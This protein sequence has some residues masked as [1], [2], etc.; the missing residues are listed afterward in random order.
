M[1]V[2]NF[3]RKLQSVPQNGCASLLSHTADRSLLLHICCVTFRGRNKRNRNSPPNGDRMGRLETK[4]INSTLINEFIG[5]TDRS[6]CSIRPKTPPLAWGREEGWNPGCAGLPSPQEGMLADTAICC[7]VACSLSH[8]WV[9][10]SCQSPQELS[11]MMVMVTSRQS[12]Q[13]YART[14]ISSIG[15]VM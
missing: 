9:T 7:L 13:S 12:K 4:I 11:F 6:K 2:F 15:T 5:V 10:V 14:P 3:A 1:Y 8:D